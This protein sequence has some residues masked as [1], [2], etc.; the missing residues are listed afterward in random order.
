MEQEVYIE[1]INTPIGWLE[2][3]T[4]EEALLSVSFAETEGP[5]SD[6]FPAILNDSAKQL[7]EYFE[8][9]RKTFELK[10]S[11]SGTEFQ[12]LV[13]ENVKAISFGETATYLDIAIR[14]GSANNTRAVGLANGKNPIPII[15][16][17]HRIIGS[18]GKLT[19]YAGGIDK[20]RWLLQHE[21]KHSENTNL[22][23]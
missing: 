21:L 11:P 4:D 23:F 1:Y 10:L 19:G 22:L 17:C 15:I 5:S 12:Q 2:L 14:T 20:K 7:I 8:G 13:W 6:N 9:S 18:N 16:P 3:K